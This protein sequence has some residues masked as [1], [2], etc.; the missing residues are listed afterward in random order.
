MI[1]GMPVLRLEIDRLKERITHA[2]VMHEDE[3]SD[4]VSAA[5]D[6]AVASFPFDQEVERIVH[7]ETRR[8]IESYFRM[9]D[10][11]RSIDAVINQ[12]F[13]SRER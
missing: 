12:A 2:L 11:R 9:G 7:D 5:I 8:A 3:L 4:A 13:G 10:G 1:N 6:K